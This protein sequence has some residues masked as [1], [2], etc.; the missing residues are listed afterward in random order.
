MIEESAKKLEKMAAALLS[1]LILPVIMN[2]IGGDM[3]ALSTH[4]PS[5]LTTPGVT[6]LM[7]RCG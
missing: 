7:R 6:I 1:Q 2:K 4:V 3:I 5:L